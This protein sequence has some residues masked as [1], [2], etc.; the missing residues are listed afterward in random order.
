M[1]KIAIGCIFCMS[2][3]NLFRKEEM[4]KKT[5]LS[6]GLFQYLQAVWIAT[7]VKK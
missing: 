7:I 1:F 2:V 5:R 3:Y 4:L 6:D